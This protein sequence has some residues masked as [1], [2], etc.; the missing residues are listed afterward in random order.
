VSDKPPSESGKRPVR[1]VVDPVTEAR[2][3]A[4]YQELVRDFLTEMGWLDQW[5][6]EA[7]LEGLRGETLRIMQE[8]FGD[9]PPALTGHIEAAGAEECRDLI[10]RAV[11]AGSIEELE[12]S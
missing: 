4:E 3:Q 10:R 11:R 6:A 5:K 7:Y 1:V 9:L 12:L 8:K 2:W